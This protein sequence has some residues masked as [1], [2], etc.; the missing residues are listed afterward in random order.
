LWDILIFLRGRFL[1]I[2]VFSQMSFHCLYTLYEAWMLDWHLRVQI[3]EFLMFICCVLHGFGC[4]SL[5]GHQHL[6]EHICLMLHGR[7]IGFPLYD[8]NVRLAYSYQLSIWVCVAWVLNWHPR[9]QVTWFILVNN[10]SVLHACLKWHLYYDTSQVFLFGG[11][12]FTY[13]LYRHFYVHICSM[14]LCFCSVVSMYAANFSLVFT[15]QSIHIISCF[16]V[17][18]SPVSMFISFVLYGVGFLLLSMY[19]FCIT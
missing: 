8:E 2:P 14:L 10:C 13:M 16:I 17:Y 18:T 3:I 11:I 15:Y 1:D 6:Y 7:L 4:S 12:W 9:G 19:M 5:N